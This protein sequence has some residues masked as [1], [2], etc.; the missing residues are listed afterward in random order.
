MLDH[1]LPEWIDDN[2]PAAHEHVIRL[3][4]NCIVHIRG[5][6]FPDQVLTGGKHKTATLAHTSHPTIRSSAVGAQS[7]I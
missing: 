5:E 6:V 7:R 1:D 4:G 3:I 2:A